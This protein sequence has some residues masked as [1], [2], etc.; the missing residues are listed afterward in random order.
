MKNLCFKVGDV[1]F[2]IPMP[3]KKD[4]RVESDN[5][6]PAGIVK[7][8]KIVAHRPA[9]PGEFVFSVIKHQVML[10][11]EGTKSAYWIVK[12]APVTLKIKGRK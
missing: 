4:L 9:K 11:T 12:V 7:Q 3:S 2:S 5:G 10:K 6:T 1:K 8:Y